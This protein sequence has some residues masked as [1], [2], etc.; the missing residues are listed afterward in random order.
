MY[1]ITDGKIYIFEDK[2]S[3][4]AKEEL[5]KVIGILLENEENKAKE[6]YDNYSNWTPE[7]INISQILKKYDNELHYEIENELGDY[8]LNLD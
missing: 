8:L 7:L 1:N 6:F 5:E 2:I 3:S 4:V